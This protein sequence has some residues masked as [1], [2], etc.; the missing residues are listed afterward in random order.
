[1]H[2]QE[3]IT[4]A[5][6][7]ETGVSDIDEQH[8]ILVDALNE[9]NA[10]LQHETR[11]EAIDQLLQD[12]LAYAIY[13]FETEEMLMREHGYF[14][15]EPRVAEAHLAQHR[16]FAA[17][18]VALRERFTTTGELD[19]DALL[20]FLNQWLTGH[21]LG[22]DQALGRYLAQRSVAGTEVR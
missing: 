1:M 9:A 5:P 6:G 12:L 16:D 19:R 8:R 15:A 11:R 4:W 2:K 3:I 20:G 10:K 13:H 18:V 17:R 21:I 14:A 22:I 7:F